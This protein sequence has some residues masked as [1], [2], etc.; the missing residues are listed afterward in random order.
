MEDRQPY[1]D[2]ELFA[3]IA[4]G[5]EDAFR[6]I[7]HKYNQKLYPFI[8][9]MLKSD[10]DTKEILQETFLK[11]WLRQGTLSG[12]EKPEAWLHTL[13]SNATFDLLR[14]QARYALRLKNLQ[15]AE[16]AVDSMIDELDAKFTSAMI[17]EAVEN[18]PSRQRLV[19][20]MSRIDGMNR[21]EIARELEVSENTVR[22]QMVTA[23]NFIQDYLTRK[24]AIYVPVLILLLAE[25]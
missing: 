12:I 25:F 1:S 23:L 22:N 24:G 16:E 2:L 13:A 19:F 14:T 3:R 8:F 15:P 6:L 5:D 18:L 4:A 21:R 10:A 11:L 7:F 20:R 9:S 17:S